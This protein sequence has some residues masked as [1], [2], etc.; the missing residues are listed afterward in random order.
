M[1]QALGKRID[2]P[3]RKMGFTLLE[4]I[5]STA[6]SS[7]VMILVYSS[8][9]M[10]ARLSR[11]GNSSVASIAIVRAV[12][13]QMRDDLKRT[14]NLPRDYLQVVSGISFQSER[15]SRFFSP[16]KTEQGVIRLSSHCLLVKRE[17][18]MPIAER[19]VAEDSDEVKVY[20]ASRYV[21]YIVS[22]TNLVD[23]LTNALGSM[24]ASLTVQ[25]GVTGNSSGLHRCFVSQVDG[26]NQF[27]LVDLDLVF[28]RDEVTAM[29]FEYFENGIWRRATESWVTDPLGVRVSLRTKSVIQ[30]SA[31]LSLN[32]IDRRGN[33]GN[34][35]QLAIKIENPSESKR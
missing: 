24:G 18:A 17:W 14:S 26:G 5:I 32:P 1:H 30:E 23:E 2:L 33:Q 7:V 35:N 21:A 4:V 16:P 34:W 31:G 9:D 15:F 8:I 10:A 20:G 3:A 28:E 13:F 27:H 22:E 12:L 25:N 29:Q 11:T 6:L 19:S